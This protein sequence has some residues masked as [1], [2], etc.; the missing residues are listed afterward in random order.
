MDTLSVQSVLEEHSMLVTDVRFS[1]NSTRLATS[2]FDK[3]VR[4]WDV[5]HVSGWSEWEV[6][7][8]QYCRTRIAC[9]VDSSYHYMGDDDCSVMAV[10]MLV[11]LIPPT[12][13][14][15]RILDECLPV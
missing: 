14:G 10:T 1:P 15:L 9:P 7:G 8:R 5:D 2:S 12:Q 4:V 11:F 13:W 3:T 6:N